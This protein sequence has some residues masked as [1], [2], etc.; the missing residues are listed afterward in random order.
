M[1]RIG[2]WLTASLWIWVV[3]VVNCG[4]QTGDGKTPDNCS[5][6]GVKCACKPD[7]T[8]NQGLQCSGDSC[9]AATG[10]S[11]GGSS[12]VGS[13][14]IAGSYSNIGG[15]ATGWVL[16]VTGGAAAAGGLGGVSSIPGCY[17]AVIN[18]SLDAG[19]NC[20]NGIVET[21]NGEQCDDANRNSGD[22]CSADC[23][24]EPSWVCP[25]ACEL[26]KVHVVCGDGVVGLGE[27]CDDG[28]VNPSDGCDSVC[29]MDPGWTCPVAGKSCRQLATCGDAGAT[30]GEACDFDGGCDDSCAIRALCGDAIVQPPETCDDG[31]NDGSYGGCT[32]DCQRAAY[33]GD[34]VTNGNEECDFGSDNSPTYNPS[35]GSCMTNCQIGPHCGDGIVQNAPEQCDSGQYNG[36]A[37]SHCTKH[38][39][40]PDE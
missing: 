15:T 12:A 1:L 9:I 8:C 37:Y 23:Q 17:P 33:C 27:Q 40:L 25:T 36:T 21:A 13:P 28:N 7:G 24:I 39:A 2:S 3:A 16:P 18:L 31:F 4:G 14:A 38:C 10:G 35:Y 11:S 26:C 6:G 22:G 5:P 30:A 20:G 29:N 34:G 32:P 19:P